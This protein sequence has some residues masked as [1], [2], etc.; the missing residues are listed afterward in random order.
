VFG[1][2]SLGALVGGLLASAAGLRSTLV[3]TSC[4]M[5]TG[6]AISIASPLRSLRSMPV[7]GAA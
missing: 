6:M 7:P 4:L 5:L 3:A 2:Q 1:F